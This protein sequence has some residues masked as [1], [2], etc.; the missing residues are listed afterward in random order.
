MLKHI[1]IEKKVED[2]YTEE[3][4]LNIEF[5]LSTEE[6]YTLD[7]YFYDGIENDIVEAIQSLPEQ[8]RII[9]QMSRF[10]DL[11]YEEIARKLDI[12]VNTVKT[13][14][15]RALEKLRT[16]MKKNIIEHHRN[17]EMF[18]SLIILI[19]LFLS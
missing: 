1:Q 16:K 15:R 11:T 2:K 10:E 19:E 4:L 7:D 14:I 5:V 8:C 3:T 13:Q 12:S 18:I 6:A 17:P 9:F